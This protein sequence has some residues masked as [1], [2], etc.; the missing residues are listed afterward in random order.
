[1]PLPRWIAPANPRRVWVLLAIGTLL[2]GWRVLAAQGYLDW[3]SR[4]RDKVKALTTEDRR[5][6]DAVLGWLYAENGVDAHVE[7]L[8]TTGREPLE[9]YSLRRMRELRIGGESARR[10]LLLVYDRSSGRSRIEVGADLEGILTDAFVGHINRDNLGQ[11]LSAGEVRDGLYATLFMILERLREAALGNDFDPRVLGLV[12]DSRR[13]A[14]GAG[15]TTRVGADGTLSSRPATAEERA[16]FSPQPTVQA[17]FQRFHKWLAYGGQPHDVP[18]FTATSSEW[19]EDSPNT[20]AFSEMWLMQEYGRA[21]RVDERG[22]LAMLFFTDSPFAQPHF[23][24]KGKDGWQLDL[25]GELLNTRNVIGGYSWMLWEGGD[26]FFR[27]FKDRF[28]SY[29]GILRPGG[30][31]N[32]MLPTSGDDS[33]ST[34]Y[35]PPPIARTDSLLEHLTVVEA[36][37]RIRSKRGRPTLVV[38]YETWSLDGRGPDLT[39]LVGLVDSVQAAGVEV[40]AFCISQHEEP[41]RDLPGLL[42]QRKAAF[43]AVH[44]YDWW[45]GTLVATLESAGAHLEAP[46][47]APVVMLVSPEGRPLGGGD[48]V[49]P[50]ATDVLR[51]FAR[52]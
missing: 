5:K 13:L 51:G 47:T 10:G 50:S 18:L 1:M 41:L 6:F 36:A 38:L 14:L 19:F 48:Y 24:R 8:P 52:H 21:Y 17:A 12:A 25:V 4:V 3:N 46:F 30:G 44:I 32:R 27:A 11:Y 39:A 16:Y 35:E 26:D 31:D 15:Q 43:P 29:E 2:I 34:I 33:T 37:D 23:F 42:R 22:K 45:P 28:V 7:L 9:Q 40:L 49:V 20:R